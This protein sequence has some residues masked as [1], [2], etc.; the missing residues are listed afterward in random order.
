MFAAV[1]DLYRGILPPTLTV[2]FMASINFFVYEKTRRFMTRDEYVNTTDASVAGGVNLNGTD[3]RAVA[4][5]AFTSG[6]I[7]SLLSAPVSM[8][9]VQQQVVSQLGMFATARALYRQHGGVRVFYRAYP[10]VFLNETYGRGAYFTMYESC[11]GWFANMFDDSKRE[12]AINEQH[13]L[14][15]TLRVRMMA[16]GVAGV[17]SWLVIYPMDV[18]K[19]KL[20]ID[21]HGNKYGNSVINCFRITY[22]ESGVA[23]LTRGLGY[24]LLRAVPVA[25]TV[26]PIYEYARDVLNEH[27]L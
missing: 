6:C 18:I 10:A 2:G 9:K 27:I 12:Y 24:T 13:P 11:K 1:R 4:A 7:S 16:A 26:L 25:S 5:G 14:A 17:F 20:Q 3:I 21:V 23:G 8:V 19:S 22:N 15:S